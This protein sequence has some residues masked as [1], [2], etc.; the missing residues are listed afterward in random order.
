MFAR[1]L[2]TLRAPLTRTTT[3]ASPTA[4]FVRNFGTKRIFV[5]NLPWAANT[6]DLSVLFGRYGEVKDAKIM[7]DRNTGRSRGFGFIE[8]EEN[9]AE[10]AIEALNGRDYKGRD[11]RINEATPMG[12]GRSDRNFGGNRGGDFGGNR[13][14]DRW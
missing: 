3:L 8:M 5:G 13:G 12:Q 2:L 1:S 10:K 9:G 11:L 4:L 14:G 7:I 6:E